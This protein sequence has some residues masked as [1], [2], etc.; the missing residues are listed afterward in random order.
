VNEL[1]SKQLSFRIAFGAIGLAFLVYT[2]AWLQ[3]A[4]VMKA[5][6]AAFAAEEITAGRSLTYIDVS[7][8]GYPFTL[9][10][11]VKDVA[12]TSSRWGS[13][14]TE[15]L[16]IVAVPFQPNKI[17]L[18]PRGQQTAEL[19]E[20]TYAVTAD[21]L[22]F[23]LQRD[24]AAIET[25][26]LALTGDERVIR[27][28]DGIINRRALSNGE[29]FAL[30]IQGLDLGDEAGTMFHSIDASAG[31]EAGVTTLPF[32]A[33]TVGRDVAEA[34]T[35]LLAEGD[36]KLE[37]G[38][39]PHGELTLTMAHEAAL[40]DLLTETGLIDKAVAENS[41]SFFSLLKGE[42]KEELS[43]PLTLKDGRIKAGFIPLGRLPRL[44]D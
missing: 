12:W 24:F 36:V 31:R 20:E 1:K 30:S 10:G 8:A 15:N 7:V 28:A 37:A 25:H 35:L 42:G 17:V 27:V 9:R 19:G 6:I 23:S 13:F 4:K 40:L 16:V 39:H 41:S 34:P 22:R 2:L 3:G 26:G 18:S 33:L 38:Q 21:D 11:T 29:T 5:E 44:P 14:T 43:V 32:V